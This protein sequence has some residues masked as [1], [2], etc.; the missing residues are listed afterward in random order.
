[1]L[2][3]AAPLLNG[4]GIDQKVVEVIGACIT[5]AIGLAS[6]VG[7]VGSAISLL[8]VLGV[9]GSDSQQ[10]MLVSIN[11]KVQEIH[12]T[13]IALGKQD[14][15]NKVVSEWA[16]VNAARQELVRYAVDDFPDEDD[17][18]L[19]RDYL[20]S[21]R[22]AGSTLL[23]PDWQR[24]VFTLSYFANQP[25]YYQTDWLEP[26]SE[27]DAPPE[28]DIKRFREQ[29]IN[30][31]DYTPYIGAI[32]DIT[33]VLLSFYKALDPAYRT[34]RQFESEIREL[35]DGLQTFGDMM[36]KH[37][38]WTREWQGTDILAYPMVS[39]WPVGAVDACSGAS[40]FTK[41]WNVGVESIQIG[42][43]SWY[44]P[45]T[46]TNEE[47]CLELAAKH[48]HLDWLT[49]VNASGAPKVLQMAAIIKELATVPSSS[50]TVETSI[51]K[52]AKRSF[53]E[54][55]QRKTPATLGCDQVTFTTAIN[56]VQ[57]EIKVIATL[58]SKRDQQSYA[59]PYTFAVESYPTSFDLS[60][61]TGIKPLARVELNEQNESFTL[62]EVTTFDWEIKSNKLAT[63]TSGATLQKVN[64]LRL[65]KY[66]QIATKHPDVFYPIMQPWSPLSSFDF[67]SILS[68]PDLAGIPRNMGIMREVTLEYSLE[69]HDG[70]ATIHFKNFPE[71]GNF[72][73]VYLVIE[74]Q[75]R[76]LENES[77]KPPIRTLID[78]SMIGVEFHLPSE[79]F[80][81]I[82]MCEARSRVI[83]KEIEYAFQLK[84]KPIPPWDPYTQIPIHDWVNQVLKQYPTELDGEI[85]QQ[86]KIL[87]KL[88]NL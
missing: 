1:M 88:S 35:A 81:Y 67:L 80:D 13:L 69:L 52:L 79:Y 57:R 14:T 30:R 29:T 28:A 63:A 68:D 87:S 62:K 65:D 55:N 59:I 42:P 15:I 27:S 26:I 8:K 74:E 64:Q 40:V 84:Q 37:I 24:D 50:E 86:A 7:T 2:K 61:Y 43:L 53:V 3:D 71:T 12:N 56:H 18:K 21:L 36:V 73:G 25:W 72:A 66:V 5:L 45:P 20:K 70:Q 22:E 39:G 34:T 17:R 49:V 58:Q 51:R 32:F 6:V 47:K 83:V 75:P 85:L 11:K 41:N 44:N 48:R 60:A 19:L 76:S 23:R 38:L 78:I 46:V 9:F 16:K 33:S 10:N 31:W 54:N 82:A 4:I 77:M